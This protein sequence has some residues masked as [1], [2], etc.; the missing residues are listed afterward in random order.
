MSKSIV[1]SP[2]I[3]SIVRYND[4][5]DIVIMLMLLIPLTIIF[6]IIISYANDKRV[7]QYGVSQRRNARDEGELSKLTSIIGEIDQDC[8]DNI[9]WVYSRKNLD[10][11]YE[12]CDIKTVD[13]CYRWLVCMRPDICPRL[14][15]SMYPDCSTLHCKYT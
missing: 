12:L 7:Y 9:R 5:I 6:Y 13:D 8:K 11:N 2:G 4:T 15:N 10:P 3:N 14:N 1:T